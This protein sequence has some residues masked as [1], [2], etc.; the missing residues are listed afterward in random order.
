MRRDNG[1][2]NEKTGRIFRVNK[3][4]FPIKTVLRLRHP[5]DT[6]RV[7]EKSKR[8]EHLPAD[9]GSSSI[10]SEIRPNACVL[11]LVHR[12]CARLLKT[13]LQ[14]G[15]KAT[16]RDAEKVYVV[17][18]FC[19]VKEQKKCPRVEEMKKSEKDLLR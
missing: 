1:S 14:V 12:A 7:N 3:Y 16:Q 9:N 8:N 4:Q 11:K 6:E 5:V 10:S 2:G 13:P 15:S 17:I 19:L 18:V